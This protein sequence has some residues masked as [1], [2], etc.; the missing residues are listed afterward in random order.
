[1]EN[2]NIG[3]PGKFNFV[4]GIGGV[5]ESFIIACELLTSESGFTVVVSS[6]VVD[7]I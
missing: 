7:S 2:T 1:M 5:V 6:S 4:L 3:V